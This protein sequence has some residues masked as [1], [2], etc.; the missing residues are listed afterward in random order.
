M[1]SGHAWR[2]FDWWMVL[3]VVA[4]VAIGFAAIY[5]V[6]LSLPVGDLLSVKKQ[7]IALLVGALAGLGLALTHVRWFESLSLHLYV[8]GVV[9][10]VLVLFFGETIRG[11]TGWFVL[12]GFNIQPV[13][14]AKIAL[15]LGLAH[16]LARRRSAVLAWRDIAH[17]GL[18]AGIPVVLVF[19]QPDLGS[20][21]VLV[22]VWGILLLCSRIT[23]RQ[24]LALGAL[25][26]VLGL[27]GW[28]FLAG[29]QQ[30]RLLSFLHP[31][32][33]PLGGGYNVTQAMIAVGSGQWFG[34]GLGFGSQS[35]LRF[36]PEAHTDFVAA[37]VAE[38]LGFVGLTLL[39]A[40]FALLFWRLLRLASRAPDDFLRL[41]LLGTTAVL[42]IQFF[43]N[44]GMNLGLLPV[45][46]ITLPFVSYGGSSLIFFLCL[47]GMAQSTAAHLSRT[48]GGE[49]TRQA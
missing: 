22:G 49:G 15:I 20:A 17:T 13:E 16:R 34:R 40:A 30:E 41:F 8:L 25:F 24:V 6:A 45:T 29:Y 26:L 43:V 1:F 3:A 46:G 19:L 35:Q 7:A 39:C 2:Q 28:Q 4:L 47:I 38:E 18:L 21:L 5:S 42:F 32:A 31:A 36:I 23:S 44:V 11:T 27:L 9:L 37:V 33:D 14:F 10:L 48:G 12:P